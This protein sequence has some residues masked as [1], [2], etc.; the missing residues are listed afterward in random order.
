MPGI[1]KCVGT[2]Y[3]IFFVIIGQFYG[4]ALLYITV[5]DGYQ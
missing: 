3:S 1:I 4:D 2:F 5:Y